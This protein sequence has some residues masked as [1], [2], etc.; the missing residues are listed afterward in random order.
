MTKGANHVLPRAVVQKPISA[1]RI[2]V[3]DDDPDSAESFM[4]VLQS[5]GHKG[6]FITD[7]LDALPA[8]RR[9]QPELVFL[10]IA[11]PVVD[12]YTLA[13]VFRAAFGFDAIRLVAVTGFTEKEDRVRARE[14]GFDAHVGKPA[15]PAIIE[16]ILH[17]IFDPGNR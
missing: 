6:E 8:A 1:R 13:R 15:D 17:T 16:S 7:P 3:V 11:M 2:L 4:R 5:M 9:L 10:D 12:G 14:A